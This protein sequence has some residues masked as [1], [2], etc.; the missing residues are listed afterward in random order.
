VK[1][2]IEPEDGLTPILEAM[3]AAK[4]SIEIAIF[5]CDRPEIERALVQAVK[6]S[7]AVQALIAY[8][9]RG[10]ESRLR[11]LEMRLLAAGATVVRTNDDLARYHGKYLIIDRKKLF[12]LGFNFTS[13]D[14]PATRSFGVVSTH[15]KLVQEGLKLFAA[16]MT[17]QEYQS[18]WRGLVGSPV[19]AR[20][21]LSE[22]LSGAC[23]ELLIYDPE[24]GDLEILR[25]L[26]ARREAGVEI[27]VI[28]R[29]K[30]R[31]SV[32][33]V[34][35]SHP[36]RLHAR[37]IVRDGSDVFL[38][39]QSLRRLE[40]DMRR[41]V[42]VFIADDKIAARVAAVFEEDWASAQEVQTSAEKIAKK[43]A[44]VMAKSMIPV[45]PV[46]EAVAARTGTK[47]TVDAQGVQEAVKQAVKTA[48]REALN[49]A[50]EHPAVTPE[51]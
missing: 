37:M 32:V 13:A 47:L 48:V 2:F 7:V 41:E 17:R 39:S 19:N 50:V 51:N 1:L 34:R 26:Q 30:T 29:V 23:K 49:E 46:L 8:T 9:N 5:R 18:G 35:A 45:A 33:D 3:D 38:G 16:D 25:I 6:R 12:V 20:K 11:G 10:G 31:D 24:V 15:E 42:G 22:F 14:L 40:L 4:R 21:R 28:G 36:L 27:R 43:V 44:K